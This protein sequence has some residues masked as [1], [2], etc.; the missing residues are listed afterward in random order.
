MEYNNTNNS[1]NNSKYA[2]NEAPM[3]SKNNNKPKVIR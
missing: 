2:G 3:K 1:N